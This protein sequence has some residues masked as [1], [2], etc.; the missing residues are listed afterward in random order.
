MKNI[1]TIL[2]TIERELIR[3]YAVLDGWFDE[4]PGVL[5][6]LPAGGGRCCSEVLEQLM[7]TNGN[8][9]S[10]I[11]M[12]CRE[13]RQRAA[14][15]AVDHT[16]DWSHYTLPEALALKRCMHTLY[17]AAAA[18]QTLSHDDVRSRMRGQLGI[19]LDHLDS[20]CHGEGTLYK[21]TLPLQEPV[22]VDVYQHLYFLAHFGRSHV[23]MLEENKAEF[24]LLGRNLN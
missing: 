21:T 15:A 9:L 16:T 20:L 23:A 11:E 13:A 2:R 18:T 1:E 8:L 3:T 6:Y 10:S 7:H 17:T 4:E 5:Q 14:E 22:T 12:A 19:C 24:A